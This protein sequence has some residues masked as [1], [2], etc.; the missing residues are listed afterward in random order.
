LNERLHPDFPFLKSE[1]L[2]ASR[3]ELAEKPN[4]IVCRRV[5]L[6]VLSREAAAQVLPQIVEILAKEKR[7]SSAQKKLELEE[8]LKNLDFIK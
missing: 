5:P 2:Y 6:G 4:D 8:A 7:W 1:V 3:H